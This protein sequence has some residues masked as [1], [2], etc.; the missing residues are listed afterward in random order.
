MEKP[1][2]TK[3]DDV[4]DITKLKPTAED[5]AILGTDKVALIKLPDGS[6]MWIPTDALTGAE[7]VPQN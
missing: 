7:P 1:L 5:I 3:R 2:V 6:L 4:V